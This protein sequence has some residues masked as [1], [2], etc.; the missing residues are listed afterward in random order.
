MPKLFNSRRLVGDEDDDFLAFTPL[1]GGDLLLRGFWTTSSDC[2]IDVRVTD[3]DGK[4]N[5]TK[6]PIKVLARQ[7]R[8]KKR[9][10]LTACLEQRRT[11][12]P[13]VV[14]VDGLLGREAQ[15]FIKR[16]AALRAE[17]W[18]KSYSEVCGYVRARISLAIARATHLCLRGSRIPA[19]QM[20]RRRPQWE[21]QAGLGLFHC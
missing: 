5:L 1:T 18:A 11:F 4:S 16:L 19:G 7:V 6:D 8:E 21:D 15:F 10:Y 12:T 14:S 20:S 9:K 2:I 3:L 17:K 13:F